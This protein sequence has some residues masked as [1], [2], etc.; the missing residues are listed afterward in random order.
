MPADRLNS[1][2]DP[3][4]DAPRPVQI[5]QIRK[6]DPDLDRVDVHREFGDGR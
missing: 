2:L 6:K 4:D 1:L 3:R 5:H